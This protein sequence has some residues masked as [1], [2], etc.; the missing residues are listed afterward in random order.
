MFHAALT[1]NIA[2]GKSTVLGLF[3]DWGATVIAAEAIVRALQRPG[4]P[5]FDAIAARFGSAVLA[6]DGS[7]DRGALRRRILADAGEKPAREPIVHPAVQAER[8]RLLGG[9]SR[10]PDTIVVSDIPLLFEAMNPADFDAVVVVD[11]PEPVRLDRLVRLRGLPQPEAEALLGEQLPAAAKRSRA[12]FVI[13][14]D[15]SLDVLRDRA[16]QVWRKLRSRAR[17]GA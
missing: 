12:D 4:T 15:G 11:A 13:Y 16:W 5:V 2:A 17:A 1:G 14:N 10:R 7:L 8:R 3:A 6:P 9:L